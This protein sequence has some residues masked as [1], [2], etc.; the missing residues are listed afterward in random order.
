MPDLKNLL[1]LVYNDV[2]PYPYEKLYSEARNEPIAVFQTSGT[3]GIPKA[4]IMKHGTFAAMDAYQLIP[5]LGGEKTSVDLWRG[6]AYFNGFPLFHTGC[7][8]WLLG[9]GVFL[10]L[11]SVLPPPIPLNAKFINSVHASGRVQGSV[12]PPSFIV[13]LAGNDIYFSNLKHLEYIVY[14]GGPLS[15]E[16]GDKISSVTRLMTEIGATESAMYALQLSD[17]PDWQYVKFSRFLGYELRPHDSAPSVGNLF[18]LVFVRK[19]DLLPFQGVFSTF[20]ELH[21]YRTKELYSKHPSNPDF[22]MYRGRTDVIIA[23][24]NAEKLNPVDMEKIITS[25]STVQAALIAGHG[26]FQ[27]SLLI[28]PAKPC[29]SIDEKRKLLDEF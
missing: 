8:L 19:E 22:W 1:P 13:D 10:N 28:E 26:R 2:L 5:F 7:Y 20:P 24:S 16:T 6:S 15:K 3:T 18:E 29:S 23:F 25:H 27:A 14:A 4:V 9:F 11:V 17:H 12:L 21:E